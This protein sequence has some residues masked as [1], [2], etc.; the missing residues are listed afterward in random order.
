MKQMQKGTPERC[1]VKI[2]NLTTNLDSI[3][4]NVS[5][6]F[7]SFVLKNLKKLFATY[8]LLGVDSRRRI[9]L[10]HIKRAIC[11]KPAKKIGKHAI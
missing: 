10:L 6:F 7:N 2:T 1:K 9:A 4:Q 8:S 3:V 11:P 5:S